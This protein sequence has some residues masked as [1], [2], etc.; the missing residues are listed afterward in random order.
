[1]R[2]CLKV[3]LGASK[4]LCGRAFSPKSAAWRLGQHCAGVRLRLPAPLGRSKTL[5]RRAFSQARATWRI[6]YTAC[7]FGCP[8]LF[9]ASK[10]LRRRA[11]SPARCPRRPLCL[12]RRPPLFLRLGLL[13]FLFPLFVESASHEVTSGTPSL[14]TALPPPKIGTLC[15][16]SPPLNSTR[17]GTACKCKLCWFG[18]ACLV[19]APLA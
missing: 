14:R 3:P 10:T 6:H 8:W 12:P 17:L 7:V 18:P 2:F 16:R 15:P 11:F 19:S 13:T 5:R 9:G 4:S 1:M